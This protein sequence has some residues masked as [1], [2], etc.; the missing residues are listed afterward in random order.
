MAQKFSW[1]GSRRFTTGNIEHLKTVIIGGGH[2][3]LTMSYYLGQLGRTF[4]SLTGRVGECW[5]WNWIKT[6]RDLVDCLGYWLPLRLWLAET[7]DFR[8]DRRA[9]LPTGGHE[10]SWDVFPWIEMAL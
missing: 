3:G 1:T 6:S 8:R 4:D 2:A 10:F 7:T 9:H 5:R